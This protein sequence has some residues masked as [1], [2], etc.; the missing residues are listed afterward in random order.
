MLGNSLR[1]R[2]KVASHKLLVLQDGAAPGQ[3][4]DCLVIEHLISF[5]CLIVL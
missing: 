5:L 1:G 3:V 2:V 4:E